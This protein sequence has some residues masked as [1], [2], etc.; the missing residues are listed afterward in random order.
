MKV[1][2]SFLEL[3]SKLG[4]ITDIDYFI[5]CHVRTFVYTHTRYIIYYVLVSMLKCSDACVITL[6]AQI[7]DKN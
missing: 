4:G 7:C 3:M 1:N 2:H 6:I 5:T